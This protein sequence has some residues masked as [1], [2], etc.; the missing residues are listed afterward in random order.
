MNVTVIGAG[1]SGLAMAAHLSQAGH[2]VSLWNRSRTTIA[3][4]M[5]TRL[6][7]CEG[8]INGTI[9]IDQVTDRIR[10]ALKNPDII[11]ITTPANS[12]KELADFNCQQHHKGNPHRSEPRKNLWGAGVSGNVQQTQYCSA[13]NHC[14]N[15][16]HHLHLP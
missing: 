15:A 11:L 6:I 5:E 10:D 7:Y 14:G 3:R 4:L 13:S 2:R 9:A 16:N 8:V 1:N 12:H